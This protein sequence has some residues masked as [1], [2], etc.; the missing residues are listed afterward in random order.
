MYTAFENKIRS[1]VP[2]TDEEIEI[3][4]REM[5]PKFIPKRTVLVNIGDICEYAYFIISGSIRFFY[6]SEDG[7]EVTGTIFTENMFAAPHASFLSHIPSTYVLESIEECNSL[8]ISYSSLQR[9]YKSIPKMHELVSKLL[10]QRLS[11][12][13]HV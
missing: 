7:R 4:G 12:A 13:H 10:E 8:S 11:I 9:L 2:F 1:L 3:I 6:I 5:K